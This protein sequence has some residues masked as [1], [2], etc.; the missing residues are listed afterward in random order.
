MPV[1]DTSVTSWVASVLDPGNDM[2]PNS[3]DILFTFMA[4]A[5]EIDHIGNVHVK[6]EATAENGIPEF[7]LSYVDDSPTPLFTGILASWEP[8]QRRLYVRDQ[9]GHTHRQS[10]QAAQ[11][12]VWRA[13]FYLL[14]LR[15]V[16]IKWGARPL[17]HQ[18]TDLL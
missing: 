13:R 8:K 12:T 4:C 15:Q 1:A 16:Q 6:V 9:A 14:M 11:D 17:M 3:A 18:T 7:L 2:P 10:H 5:Q